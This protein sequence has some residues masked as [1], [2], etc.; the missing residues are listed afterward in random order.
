MRLSSAEKENL[1]YSAF[2]LFAGAI[3]GYAVYLNTYLLDGLG[4][5]TYEYMLKTDT[6]SP[7]TGWY[8]GV[9]GVLFV[10]ALYWFCRKVSP[11]VFDWKVLGGALLPLLILFP[12][13][14]FPMGFYSPMIF[15]IVAGLT[16]F[17]LALVIPFKQKFKPEI[18]S[19]TG[20]LTVL[21]FTVLQVCWFAFIQAKAVKILFMGYNDWGLYFNIID[22][23]LKGK[24][25][26][27]DLAEGSFL[28][29][30]FEPG[31][32]LLL[33]PYV[34]LFR[35]PGAFFV[36]TS[37]LLFCGGIFVYLFARQLKIS[38]L[39]AL[40]LAF[41]ALLFPSLSNMNIAIFYGFHS[42]YVTIPLI[43]LYFYF[44]EKKNYIPAFCMFLISLTVKETVAI[45]WVGLGLVYLIRGNRKFGLLLI[46]VACTY[47]LTIVKIVVPAISPQGTY[48]YS[49][50]YSEYGGMV[51]MLLAPF[52]KPGLF[53]GTL[54]RPHCIAF[55]LLLIIP[56]YT[57]LLSR[58]LLLLAG[59]ITI[60][61]V[62]LQTNDQLQNI[63]IWYQSEYV[64]LLL[65]C[66]VLN[67][68]S[69]LDTCRQRTS[70]WFRAL[71]WKMDLDS[72]REKL[73]SAVILSLLTTACFS[74]YFFGLS[75]TGKNSVMPILGAESCDEDVRQLLQVIPP[76]IEVTSS[77]R[78]GAHLI[79]RNPVSS[80]YLGERKL[81]DYVVF[82]VNDPLEVRFIDPA[83]F[84]LLKD[85]EYNLIVNHKF[86][87][88][89]VLIFHREPQKPQKPPVVQIPQD[90]W[91]SSG[92]NI[93]V[94]NP[95]F[96]VRGGIAGDKAGQRS[97]IFFIRL[98][99]KVD[100]DVES[101]IQ[102]YDGK[103]LINERFLF[104]DAVYPA[105]FA[106]PGECFP[107]RIPLPDDFGDVKSFSVEIRE[108]V[109]VL[110]W[111]P[112][113]TAAGNQ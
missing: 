95:N 46:V 33:A 44:F 45:F 54:F 49:N 80:G 100:L 98:L 22:N 103:K 97:A 34:W 104:G 32:V 47:F 71:A 13:F 58:P 73:P 10:A 20:L 83:R 61:F 64:A 12:T 106:Q 70:P 99:N 36:L 27:A 56:L 17:R 63:S 43:F 109:P 2:S 67:Y 4:I 59:G 50:R 7:V 40:A 57:L 55:M 88:H 6:P 110:R 93:P 77:T 11:V 101:D 85:K 76:G 68:R 29:T 37:A 35:T 24:W 26:Y 48:D 113:D 89:Q 16:V 53:W 1:F 102:L 69:L 81:K 91:A 39:A 90:K 38:P 84:K 14:F 111:S 23:T 94:Q 8:F 62:C 79:L 19:R 92:I 3:L 41:C 96:A 60:G 25:F 82:D 72:C 52:L 74:Y 108:R 18:S 105:C 51:D 78:I 66:L 87:G 86:K 5:I 30:H 31:M 42:L 15:T 65:A 107:V 75:I 112:S 9:L 21:V 28:P